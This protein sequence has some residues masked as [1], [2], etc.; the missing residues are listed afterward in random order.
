MPLRNTFEADREYLAAVDYYVSVGWR[1]AVAFED[2]FLVALTR[3]AADPGSLPLCLETGGSEV[4]F[5][6]VRGFPYLVLFRTTDPA[7]TVVL[8]VLHAAAGPDRYRSAERRG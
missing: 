1:I 5:L 3:I 6:K 7:D 4:R 8:A 2:A